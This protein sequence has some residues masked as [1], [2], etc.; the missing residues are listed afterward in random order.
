MS[1]VR[2]ITRGALYLPAY[3]DASRRRSGWDEDPFTMAATALERLVPRE[4][5]GDPPL[6]LHLGGGL[7]PDSAARLRDVVGR[8]ITI[9]PRAEASWS[10]WLAEIERSREPDWLV[11]VRHEGAGGPTSLSAPG[12]GAIALRVDDSTD[13]LPLE[14]LRGGATGTV[15]AGAE[16]A[17]AW[18]ALH[19][20]GAAAGWPGDWRRSPGTGRARAKPGPTPRG[21]P[22][23]SQGAFVP[24]PRD[25]EARP[26]RWRFIADRCRAC[27]RLTFPPRGR[28]RHCRQGGPLEPEPLPL[29]GAKVVAATWIGPGG[30]PTE[31]DAQVAVS[32]A[33]GVVL[34]ELAPD[35]TVTL[36][37]ADADPS[38]VA[39]GT[40]V[41]SRLR[42][43]YEI[44]DGWRYGRKAIPSRP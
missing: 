25:E 20:A 43:L 19:E 39:I 13:A 31:F 6:R 9:L 17:Q 14:R 1:D 28:C 29:D 32:G 11:V 30:Q 8:P 44:D 36:S 37:V 35:V 15:E 4:V 22:T 2:G 27:G 42:R 16:F 18:T 38:E 33:Y 40:R 24:I 12:E 10:G 26:A 41:D 3:A 5:T 34:A 7:D 21:G 23:V